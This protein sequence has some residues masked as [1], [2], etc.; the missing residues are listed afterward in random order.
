[1]DCQSGYT[2]KSI[3]FAYFPR[4]NLDSACPAQ[5]SA[6]MWALMEGPTRPKFWYPRKMA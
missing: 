4:A 2:L 5:G 3:Q 6:L 1:M